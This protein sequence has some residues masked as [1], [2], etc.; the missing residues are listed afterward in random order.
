[1]DKASLLHTRLYRALLRQGKLFDKN[2]A[3]KLLL[4][5]KHTL[6]RNKQDR[7]NEAAGYYQL[8]LLRLLFQVRRV[9]WVL[10][11]RAMCHVLSDVYI[12]Q[13]NNTLTTTPET[14]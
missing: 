4:Y 14:S 6:L 1:M 10:Q 5:R 11:Q 7:L 8:V 12:K 3:S 13:H 2:P 9:S